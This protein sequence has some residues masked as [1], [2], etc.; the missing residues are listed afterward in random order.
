MCVCVCVNLAM[1]NPP[2]C[3]EVTY[4]TTCTLTYSLFLHLPYTFALPIF[5]KLAGSS[6]GVKH[7][8]FKI[9][10]KFD[11]KSPP[12]KKNLNWLTIYLISVHLIIHQW[13]YIFQFHMSSHVKVCAR[14]SK[15]CFFFRMWCILQIQTYI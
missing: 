3:V 2:P 12:Q 13:L 10:L 9:N 11:L 4:D 15:M 1:Y 14:V 5:F 8:H 6:Q 7:L